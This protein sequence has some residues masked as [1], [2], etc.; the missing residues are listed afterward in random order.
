MVLDRQ[1]HK[2]LKYFGERKKKKSQDMQR[3]PGLLT[4]SV[5]TTVQIRLEI[6]HFLHPQPHPRF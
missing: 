1:D 4:P 5:L 2:E 6:T 3:L